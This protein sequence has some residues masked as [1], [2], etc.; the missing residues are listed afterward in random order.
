MK[1]FTQCKIC[2]K[3]LVIVVDDDYMALGDPHKLI[4][5]ACHNHCHDN[6]AM[7]MRLLDGFSRVC[8]DLH[9]ILTRN[10]EHNCDSHRPAI[11]KLTKAYAAW[12]SKSHNLNGS[13]WNEEFVNIIIERPGQW[14][15]VLDSYRKNWRALHM[16]ARQ[17]VSVNQP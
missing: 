2:R 8:M 14:A 12:M 1:H 4:P 15:K 16:P 9:Y 17:P 7:H 5:M 10:P 6:V 13:D 11:T 3:P